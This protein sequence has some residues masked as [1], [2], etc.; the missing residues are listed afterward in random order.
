MK[1]LALV[2]ALNTFALIGADADSISNK[3]PIIHLLQNKKNEIEPQDLPKAVKET[4]LSKEKTKSLPIYKA[5]EISNSSGDIIYEISFG[6]EK[7]EFTK[8]YNKKGNELEE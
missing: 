5:Y 2:F 8:K 7:I 1:K 3:T 4:I 6:L